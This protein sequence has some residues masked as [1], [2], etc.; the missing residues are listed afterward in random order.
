[1]KKVKKTRKPKQ[2]KKIL[3]EPLFEVVN[4]HEGDIIE[5]TGDMIIGDVVRAYP[6]LI[7]PLK[8]IGIHCVG[9]YASTFDSIQEGVLKHGLDPIKVCKMLNQNLH[10]KHEHN[11]K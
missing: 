5:I 8:Q 11:K 2:L 10:K 9:C 3:K 6:Q 7:D 1:M 4:I